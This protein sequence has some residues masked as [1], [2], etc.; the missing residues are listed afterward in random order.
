[1]HKIKDGITIT[2]TSILPDNIGLNVDKFEVAWKH[3]LELGAERGYNRFLQYYDNLSYN[4]AYDFHKDVPD[5]WGLPLWC[6]P[7]YNPSTKKFDMFEL[8]YDTG[9][10]EGGGLVYVVYEGRTFMKYLTNKLAVNIDDADM[11]GEPVHLTAWWESLNRPPPIETVA[12]SNELAVSYSFMGAQGP[13][14]HRKLIPAQDWDEIAENYP[15][16]L[17]ENL[18][19]LCAQTEA[20]SGGKIILLYGEP[21]VGKSNFI[22]TLGYEWSE[23]AN[24]ITILEP[25][26]FFGSAGYML[27]T[28]LGQADEEKWNLL[29]VEDAEELISDEAGGQ[30]LA[31]LLNLTDGLLGN[32]V[33]VIVLITTNQELSQ[34]KGSVRRPGRCMFEGEFGRFSIEESVE[35]LNKH[36]ERTFTAKHVAEWLE[37][38]GKNSDT[39]LTIGEAYSM[40][41]LVNKIESTLTTEEFVSGTY[42]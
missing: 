14:S 5:E 34:V 2:T 31:R 28:V 8:L 1:M 9:E 16:A 29:V 35:W 3:M 18:G 19:A 24:L 39:G 20:G 30:G 32:G 36:G 7:H 27:E 40:A 4:S 11:T 21:G 42:I 37:A 13:T 22:Q 33:R 26:R 38:N 15:A 17:R 41:G 10:W 25:E 12:K 23:W 6:E